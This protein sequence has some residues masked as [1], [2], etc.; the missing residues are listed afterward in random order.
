VGLVDGQ[1]LLDLD[2][3]EDSRADVDMNV[4]ATDAGRLAEIQGTGEGATFSRDELDAMTTL[5]LRGVEEL[6]RLQQKALA[7][8]AGSP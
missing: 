1:V 3:D 2:Y 7:E 6:T 5:A 8:A 4:V